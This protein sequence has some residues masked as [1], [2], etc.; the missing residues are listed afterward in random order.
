[1]LPKDGKTA[2]RAILRL[3]R[4]GILHSMVNFSGYKKS[5]ELKSDGV[6]RFWKKLA[7]E[8]HT[9]CSFLV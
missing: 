1:M 7:K 5:K 2:A 6:R 3:Q 8:S 4:T 9:Q